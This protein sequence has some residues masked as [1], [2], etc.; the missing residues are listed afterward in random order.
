[1]TTVNDNRRVYPR[2]GFF[3]LMRTFFL[4][5][6]IL[7]AAFAAVG[8]AAGWITFE[9]D[10]VRHEATIQIDTGEVNQAAENA[11]ER[12][13]ELIEQAGEKIQDATTG[14]KNTESV[15]PAKAP[16]ETSATEKPAPAGAPI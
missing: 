8:Y 3:W 9:H 12:G 14:S 2:H 10:K 7:I 16:E 15:Q 13:Q 1:M 6:C 4:I 11:L 5:A